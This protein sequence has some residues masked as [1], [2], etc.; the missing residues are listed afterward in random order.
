MKKLTTVILSLSL[1][2]G[3][4]S[5][6]KDEDIP[7]KKPEY[8]EVGPVAEGHISADGDKITSTPFAYRISQGSADDR[9]NRKTDYW[10]RISLFAESMF[11]SPVRYDQWT[12][13]AHIYYHYTD[14]WDGEEWVLQD[15]DIHISHE[16][17]NTMDL[18]IEVIDGVMTPS[19]DIAEI[20]QYKQSDGE[21]HIYSPWQNKEQW[22]W[23]EYI[24]IDLMIRLRLR[25]G[26]TL[27][28]VYK[29]EMP[30]PALYF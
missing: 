8:W 30:I 3:L 6:D 10:N 14:Y 17:F 15:I 7:E 25:S 24:D 1:L 23:S 11:L 28:I 21:Y 13:Q 20:L 26:Q 29:G 18:R 5:C 27:E 2:V 9:E 22:F 19:G 16:P 4:W 12:A